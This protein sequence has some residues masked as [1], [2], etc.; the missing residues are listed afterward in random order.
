MNYP[1]TTQTHKE[2]MLEEQI[3][4]LHMK[5]DSLARYQDFQ[6]DMIRDIWNRGKK[7]KPGIFMATILLIKSAFTGKPVTFTMK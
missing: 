4:L 2:K 6:S 1:N 7:I 5:I 3:K